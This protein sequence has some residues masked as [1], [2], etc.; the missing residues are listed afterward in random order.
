MRAQRQTKDHKGNE[1]NAGEEWLIRDLGYYI[2]GIDE[3][4]VEYV[5][6]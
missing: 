6:G 5:Y 4:F 2:P 1:R 3:V